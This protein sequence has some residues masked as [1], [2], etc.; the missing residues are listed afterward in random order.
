[1]VMMVVSLVIVVMVTAALRIIALPILMVMV[2]LMVVMVLVLMIVVMLMIVVVAAA[3]RI[4]ALLILVV[5]R[6]CG[7]LCQQR[8]LLLKGGAALHRGEDLVPAQFL[9]RGGDDGGGGVLLP[10]QRNRFLQLC[11]IHP[12]GAAED[13]GIG[14]ADLIVIE[15]A[16]ILHINPALGR[17][18]HGGKAVEGDLRVLRHSLHR[19][20]D[21]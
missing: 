6:V 18:S 5:V 4:V 17:I 8:N 10:Q 14:M 9:P 21:I 1:M 19:A 20:D 13:D 11:L 3:L 2:M 12:T 7:L 15:L 16:E